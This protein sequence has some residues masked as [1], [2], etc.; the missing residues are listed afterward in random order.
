MKK[1]IIIASL[2][3]AAVVGGSFYLGGGEMF[4]GKL[5][6]MPSSSKIT[7]KVVTESKSPKTLIPTKE[8]SKVSDPIKAVIKVKDEKPETEPVKES[9][10]T[11]DAAEP[12][13]AEV[14]IVEE[15]A[16]EPISPYTYYGSDY[17]PS[18]AHLLYD[19]F[20]HPD[21]VVSSYE[22]AWDVIRADY[23]A[24]LL[25]LDNGEP[26]PATSTYRF[27]IDYYD[28][29]LGYWVYGVPIECTGSSAQAHLE[30]NRYKRTTC[31]GPTFSINLEP[32]HTSSVDSILGSIGYPGQNLPNDHFNVSATDDPMLARV[33]I[34][35]VND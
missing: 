27:R 20:D 3:I 11:E 19:S 4:Q 22:E 1:K 31:Y 8:T 24:Y 23:Y 21:N 15:D 35:Q 28:Q 34:F 6:L 17:S 10:P 30:N 16:Y 29:G 9:E 5:K 33:M 7:S 25:S 18:D 26:A 12:A 32:S 13:D 2:L 14:P